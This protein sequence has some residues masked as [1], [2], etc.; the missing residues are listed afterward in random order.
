MSLTSEDKAWIK[1]EIEK[2]AA[3]I[4]CVEAS[5][6][7]EA[8]KWVDLPEMRRRTHAAALRAI[9]ADFELLSDRAR[10]FVCDH[11]TPGNHP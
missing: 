4:G 1:G 10:R 11:P 8:Q 7:T 9:D 2:V 6:L 3:K 5:L